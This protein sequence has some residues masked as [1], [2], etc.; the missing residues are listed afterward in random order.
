[1]WFSSLTTSRHL[2]RS[3]FFFLYPLSAVSPKQ[4]VFFSFIFSPFHSP[5][6]CRRV[7]LLVF[8]FFTWDWD[9]GDFL[10]FSC[11]LAIFHWNDEWEQLNFETK[12]IEVRV[13]FQQS[14][15]V[16]RL[17]LKCK[18]SFKNLGHWWFPIYV[19]TNSFFPFSFSFC[20]QFSC[21]FFFHLWHF[22][23]FQLQ[24]I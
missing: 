12:P 3:N 6:T 23:L 4:S 13:W 7:E 24:W 15:F 9:N 11:L 2:F 22:N 10:F 1:M 18:I 20:A 5:C 8:S 17:K 16:W 21:C 19:I 14:V